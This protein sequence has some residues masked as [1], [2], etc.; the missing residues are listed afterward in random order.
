MKNFKKYLSKPQKES[1]FAKKDLKIKGGF[2]RFQIGLVASLIFC[3]LLIESAFAVPK[4]LPENDIEILEE[5]MSYSVPVFEVEKEKV[6]AEKIDKS[7]VKKLD[8]D[9]KV[10]DDDTKVKAKDEF[11]NKPEPK[12]EIS[13][14][15]I[16]YEK[17]EEDVDV[18]FIAIEDKPMFEEC[19]DLPKDQQAS[20]F[21]ENLDKH[22]RR[23]FRYP[24]PAQ[25]LGIQGRVYVNFRINKD[26]TITIL[27]TR[28]PDKSLDEE[29]RRI[30]NKLPK[31]I[32]GKQRGRPT[33]VTFAYPI[34]FK[35]N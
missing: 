5:D 2:I 12:V 25:E 30:I 27:N 34:V 6:K 9:F 29:A 10:V 8:N 15:D 4:V 21:K 1:R 35:L 19:K 13:L 20:C 7:L 17:P 16:K 18:S 3:Y 11:L 24:D 28:A 31:L 33:P 22:V 14:V 32:P 26:G 23:T